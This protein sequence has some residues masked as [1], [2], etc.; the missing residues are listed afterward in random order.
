MKRLLS[1]LVLLA[2]AGGVASAG[3]PDAFNSS[4]LPSDAY[5]YPRVTGI[6]DQR[7]G[8]PN[9]HPLADL[10]VTVRNFANVPIPNA[11]VEVVFST[12][13]DDP[14]CMCDGII[15]DG[16]TDPTGLVIINLGY[17]G[18]CYVEGGAAVAVYAEGV[19][20]RAF[21]YAVSPDWDEVE[22]NCIMGLADF[23]VFGNY[24][25]SGEGGCTDYDG[26]GAT[27]LIDFTTFGQGWVQGCTPAP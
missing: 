24:W 9:P 7:D 16:Y 25:V 14:V 4:V 5:V 6:L 11:Y 2:L 13:C 12:L 10:Y 19:V 3:V 22:G 15:L 21:E 23:T 27:A 1:A 18:C 26:D 17:G 8:A 20:V